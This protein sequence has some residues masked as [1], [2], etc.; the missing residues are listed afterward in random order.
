MLNRFWMS[1]LS[2]ALLFMLGACLH[3]DEGKSPSTDT[4]ETLP[5]DEA[6]GEDTFDFDADVDVST[7]PEPESQEPAT[8]NEDTDASDPTSDT[9]TD[10]ESEASNIPL[11]E[12]A[13]L[14]AHQLDK[15][16]KKQSN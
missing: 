7:E 11:Q 1:F 10:E 9:T 14:E 8:P 2:I 13:E 15:P 4:T 16:D 5:T 12:K 3:D 6:P